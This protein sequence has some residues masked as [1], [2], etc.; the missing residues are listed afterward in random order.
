[1]RSSPSAW[2]RILALRPRSPC[3]NP[4]PETQRQRRPFR[5]DVENRLRRDGRA[6][7]R[8]SAK[9]DI[10]DGVGRR[11]Y[12][13][14]TR[15]NRRNTTHGSSSTI[16][17]VDPDPEHEPRHQ[18]L[19]QGGRWETRGSGH[20]P[21]EELLGVPYDR[22]RARLV[23]HAGEAR[24]EDAR[25]LRLHREEHQG[26]RRRTS[27]EGCQVSA[28]RTDGPGDEGGRADRVRFW[29]RFR[30]LQGYGRKRVDGVPVHRPDVTD[31]G[32]ARRHPITLPTA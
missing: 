13:S 5:S 32:G 25:L 1:M 4:A 11:L 10:L 26:I 14:P 17:D 9:L 28:G 20:G 7:V 19:H 2:V 8:T 15:E 12:I 31:P 29:R 30:L 22:R 21:D 3:P 6:L 27:E 16:G 18:V 24:K 23:G